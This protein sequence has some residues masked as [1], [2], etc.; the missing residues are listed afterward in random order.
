MV[1][2]EARRYIDISLAALTALVALYYRVDAAK[3]EAFEEKHPRIA[4]IIGM[5]AAVV[6]FIPMLVGEAKRL[7]APSNPPVAS[8]VLTPSNG[9]PNAPWQEDGRE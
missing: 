4:A 5:I 9:A 3:R 7:V 6:P 8:R 2:E 1:T